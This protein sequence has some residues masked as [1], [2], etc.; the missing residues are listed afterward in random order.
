[1]KEG[2]W[3]RV[4]QG[5]VLSVTRWSDTHVGSM[6]GGGYVGPHGGVVRAPTITSNVVQRSQVFVQR[7]D[8]VEEALELGD[9]MPL[10]E[11]QI[12][13]AVYGGMT[14]DSGDLLLLHNQQSKLTFAEPQK[15]RSGGP[16]LSFF[17]ALFGTW[18]LAAMLVLPLASVLTQVPSVVAAGYAAQHSPHS[19][20]GI[21]MD[22]A[23]H[24]YRQCRALPQHHLAPCG[25]DEEPIH[26]AAGPTICLCNDIN[27]LLHNMALEREREAEK[28]GNP[29]DATFGAALL[30]MMVVG[31]LGG[32]VVSV[33]VYRIQ[34]RLRRD[35][36]WQFLVDA[37]GEASVNANLSVVAIRK[38]ASAYLTVTALAG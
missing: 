27:G 15:V 3:V 10:R 16:I 34:M 12:I 19:L 23:I 9:L 11:G 17:L 38:N 7:S 20:D 8:G 29:A 24:R 28:T 2:S 30:I 37:A 33:M 6:G 22:Q 14:P 4:I 1:M 35:S 26:T 21:Y 36:L 13:T 32:I 25:S 31:V 18:S 5:R